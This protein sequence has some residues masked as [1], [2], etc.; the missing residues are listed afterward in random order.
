MGR[1]RSELGAER[2]KE[3]LDRSR[4]LSEERQEHQLEGRVHSEEQQL[5][6]AR[7]QEEREGRELAVRLCANGGRL[8]RAERNFARKVLRARERALGATA[9]RDTEELQQLRHEL[10]TLHLS[11]EQRQVF[12]WGACFPFLSQTKA[13]ARRAP[14]A[15]A[16]GCA[17]ISACALFTALLCAGGRAAQPAVALHRCVVWCG[18]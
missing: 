18:G 1:L 8:P 5:A 16:R 17:V 4:L 14:Q 13:G 6:K 7:G 2:R 10:A 3:A 15:G 12:F 9:H 11:N